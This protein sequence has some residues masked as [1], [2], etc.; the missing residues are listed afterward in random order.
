MVYR[1]QQLARISLLPRLSLPILKLF[2]EHFPT[3]SNKVSTTQQGFYRAA[4]RDSEIQVHCLLEILPHSSTSGLPTSQSFNNAQGRRMNLGNSY[5]CRLGTFSR[6]LRVLEGGSGGAYTEGLQ[7]IYRDLF[8]VW[9]GF[10]IPTGVRC[11]IFVRVA[12]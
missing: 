6:S 8:D 2:Y 3:R 4:E 5:R 10:L 1:L 12:I 7:S 9:F 11:I